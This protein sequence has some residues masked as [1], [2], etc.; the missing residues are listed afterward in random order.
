[1]RILTAPGTAGIACYMFAPR[2]RQA[3]L[4]CLKRSN[5]TRFA[6]REGGMQRAQLW[7]Q[8]QCVDDVLVVDCAPNVELHTHGSLAIASLLRAQFGL[9]PEAALCPAEVLRREAMSL[10][11]LDLA[12]EQLALDWPKFLTE[13]AALPLPQREQ[14]LAAALARS[15]VAMAVATPCAVVLIGSQ[16]AG[17]STLLNSLLGEDRVLVAAHAGTTRDAV[18]E[19]TCLSGYPY[20]LIDTAGMGGFTSAVDA[21]AFALGQ[22][23]RQGAI[24]LLLIDASVGPGPHDAEL[25]RAGEQA[26][27]VVATK[28]DLPPAA[29]PPEWPAPLRL[30]AKCGSSAALRQALGEHLRFVRG[31]PMAGPVGGCAALHH[32]QWAELIALQASR[33]PPL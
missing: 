10:A 32:S 1:M 6:L 26:P 31:L 27:L 18:A 8:E 3:L 19:L 15:R 30:S 24:S 23:R 9:E 13:L 28:G 16:N 20:Q 17:K 21:R 2:E 33:C 11:Q 14:E 5:G 7:L 12:F 25:L 29:W 22:L 4:Q